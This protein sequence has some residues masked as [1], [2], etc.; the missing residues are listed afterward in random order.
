MLIVAIGQPYLGAW[1]ERVGPPARDAGRRGRR[2]RR[3]RGHRARRQRLDLLLWRSLCALGYAHGVRRR[4][5]LRARPHRPRRTARRASRC[6]SAR[7]WW[8]RCA[9][10]R[11]AASWPTTSA[12]APTFG[13]AAVLAVRLDP[14]DPAAAAAT[15]APRG[16]PRHARRRT[17]RE[18]V[19]LRLQ[20]PLHDG[21]RAGGDAGQD[22]A[23]RRVLLPGAAVHRVDRQHAGDGRAHAD[24]L[25]GG[26]GADRA[27]GRGPARDRRDAPRAAAW[28]SGWCISGLGG[29]LL[30]SVG[31]F[32]VVFGVVF[33]LGLGQALSI[34]AQSALVGEHCQEEIARY[35][36]D[37]VYGVY[38]LLERLGNAL[39]PLLGE[40]AGGA[41]R[42]PRA[43]SSRISALVLVCGLA[44]RAAS[45]GSAAA[46][47]AGNAVE[48]DHDRRTCLRARAAR[49]RCLRLPA[50]AGARP[51]ARAPL[52]HLRDHLPRHDR[53]R[54]GL[55]RSTSPRARSRCEITYRD[56]NRDA[57]RMPGFVEEIRA[58]K[59]DLIYTWGTSVTLGVVGRLR[60]VDPAK[61]ITDIPV[62]FT[63]VAA[64][65][66]AKIVPDLEVLGPQR[67]RRLPRRADRGA[68]AGDGLV[69]AV[70]DARRALHADRAE[71]G[72]R[73]RGGAPA[74][75]AR[76]AS[77]V[78]AQPFTLDADKKPVTD[79][80][81]PTW[82]AS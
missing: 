10:R 73:G 43:P 17:L 2:H 80:A 34:A 74:G 67:D 35:G 68:D 77:T 5:G 78:I 27:A 13:V 1:S 66:L 50:A 40:P 11:S 64:P 71:L 49:R 6:S 44:V 48:A 26:D 36:D 55:R 53:R 3:L 82:C 46:G 23:H 61:H 52:S 28:R 31:S 75:Q 42:L 24:G 4:A 14:R 33:L 72:G 57:T 41:L 30:L 21:H 37:A 54:E 15:P 63:L 65:V 29:L 18:I 8:P 60:R 19:A 32:L 79:G 20:P 45:R 7:S 39:G 76:W 62:V 81:P 70:Q 58:T 38:R 12:T 56:L 9:A 51:G 22:P 16:A 25:R 59:P 47:H 69:P